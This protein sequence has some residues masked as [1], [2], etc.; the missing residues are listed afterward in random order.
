MRNSEWLRGYI[1]G[2]IT[3]VIVMSFLVAY[4]GSRLTS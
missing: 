2:I 4:I 3:G 1:Y